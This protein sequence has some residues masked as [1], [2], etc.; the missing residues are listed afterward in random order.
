MQ[1]HF[2]TE[3]TKLKEKLFKMGRLVEEAIR[4]AGEA[5]EKRDEG[6]AKLVIE[7]DEKINIIEIEIDEF[8]HELIALMQP[9][10]VDL[11]F[12]TMVLKINS[13]LERIADQAVNIAEKA[14]LFGKDAP[15]DLNLGISKTVELAVK[16]VN[17]SLTAFSDKD[18]KTAKLICQQDDE[19]D[20][21]NDKVNQ[22]IQKAVE[23]KKIRFPQAVSLIMVAHNLERIGDLATNI[24]EDVIYLVKGIDIRHHITERRE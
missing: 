16:M 10:A 2:D 1:R 19:V 14:I 6:I 18:A 13:D 11:R 23:E 22:E 20:D 3:L 9:T 5:L 15:T 21:W 24:A 7:R 17:E 8:G 4:K 12:I